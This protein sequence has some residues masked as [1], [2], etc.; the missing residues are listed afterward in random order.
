M[1]T[2]SDFRA[3]FY[4]SKDYPA[5]FITPHIGAASRRLRQWVG[6]DAYAD[7]S[8]DPPADAERAADLRLAEAFLTMHF[9]IA[10]LNTRIENGGILKTKKVEE[11][12]TI[13]ML[14]PNEVATL[15]QNYL[16]QAEEVARPYSLLDGTPAPDFLKTEDCE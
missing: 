8:N 12:T 5:S 6:A 4:V 13:T 7:A 11:A 10:G 3:M 14:S 16:D 15:K 1:I 2:D 9:A